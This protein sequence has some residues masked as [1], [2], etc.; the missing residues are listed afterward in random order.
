MKAAP[1]SQ[2]VLITV[3]RE[4]RE[5]LEQRAT[6]HGGTLSAEALRCIRE[7]MERQR[8]AAPDRKIVAIAE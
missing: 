1:E 3:P 6:Y 2:K 8:G 4:V 7:R 5:W